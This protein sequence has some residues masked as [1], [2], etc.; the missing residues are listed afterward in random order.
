MSTSSSTS[1]LYTMGMALDRAQENGLN[2]RVLVDGSW[3]EG[4]I[5]AYDGTGLVMESFDG[6]HSVIKA[7]RIA[8][9]TV[10]AESPYRAPLESGDAHAMPGQYAGY[11]AY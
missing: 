5:A 1:M 11:A 3:I 6:M 4:H 2:V 9:V 10:C 7:E 8:A